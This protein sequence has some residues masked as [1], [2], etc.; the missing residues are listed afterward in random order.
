LGSGPVVNLVISKGGA[1]A[2][3]AEFYD[4]AG[5]SG[6]VGDTD[7]VMAAKI[8]GDLVGV[9]RLVT[10][11]GV[12][13]LRGMQVE[14]SIQRMGVGTKLLAALI[15]YIGHHECW[16]IPYGH[17]RQFYAGAGFEKVSE[18]AAP[19]FLVERTILYNELGKSVVLMRRKAAG[20]KGGVP[21]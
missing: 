15:E 14:P 4:R 2:E 13:V 20:A 17:L 21:A 16:C 8:A 12:L 11:N 19:S 6:E 10:E 5:Y 7:V 9:A 1:S 3:V 18:V